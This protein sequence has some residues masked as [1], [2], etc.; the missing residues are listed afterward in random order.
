MSRFSGVTEWTARRSFPARRDADEVRALKNASVSVVLPARRVAGTLTAILEAL[1]PH[2]KSGLIDEL[3]V[4]LHAPGDETERIARAS[5]AGVLLRDEVLADF[6][7]SLGKG[8]ALWRGT[9][10]ATGEIVVFFDTDT[11][12]FGDHFL[13]GILAPLFEHA[14]L[15]FVKGSFHRPL[16]LGD[17]SFA[18]EGGRVTELM[19]RPLLNLFAPELAGFVQPLAGE[20]AA[21]RE[22]LRSIPFAA[23]Y[24]V[25]IAMLLD[26]CEAV[27]VNALAQADL[28]SRIDS[29]QPLRQLSA[30]SYAVLAAVA[31]RFEMKVDAEIHLARPDAATTQLIVTE[32]RPPLATLD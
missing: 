9:S 12:N 11:R 5:G 24:G 32:E 2:H 27:G 22:L 29:N 23:G 7:P 28:V 21:R 31:Q 16:S 3:I 14:D 18:E 30:M 10:V 8:D 17:S 4:M 15:Q 19:A 6:G 20:V 13:L 25:E 1:E 26:A